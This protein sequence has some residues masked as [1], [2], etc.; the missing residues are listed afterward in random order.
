MDIILLRHAESKSNKENKA[1]SQID[2]ELT[3]EGKKE[4]KELISKL[5]E[6]SIDIVIVSPLK[7]TLDTIKPFLES[8][9]S[10][11]KVIINKLTVERDLGKFTGSK[12]G[13]FQKYCEENNLDKVFQKPEGGESI[14]DTYKR[15]KRLFSYIKKNYKKKNILI[16]GHK[17]FLLCLEIVITNKKVEDYYSYQSLKIGEFKELKLNE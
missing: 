10:K 12:M 8:V 11:P 7:R 16:C 2:S 15:A 9:K 17:N 3:E 14:F 1:D 4:A 6:L 13:D 5:R